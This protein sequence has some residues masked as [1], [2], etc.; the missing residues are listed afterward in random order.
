MER[1]D[2]FVSQIKYAGGVFILLF[3]TS[4][5]ASLFFFFKFNLLLMHAVPFLRN[6]CKV[7]KIQKT[8]EK[9]GS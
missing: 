1:K 3:E 7:R 9:K 6:N 4:Q 5:I 2:S 8:E